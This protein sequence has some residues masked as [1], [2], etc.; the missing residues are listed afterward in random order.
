MEVAQ[1]AAGLPAE[2]REVVGAHGVGHVGEGGKAAV[3]EVRGVVV[4]Q[5]VEQA[6]GEVGHADFIGVRKAEREAGLG[7]VPILLARVV[8][9]REVL[10]GLF[11]AVE[12]VLDVNKHGRGGLYCHVPILPY[13]STPFDTLSPK[14]HPAG[15]HPGNL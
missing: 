5:F 1:G 10:G 7:R 13:R 12:Q 4:D 3:A 6:H 9:A 2:E 14:R 11:D 8:L 15:H